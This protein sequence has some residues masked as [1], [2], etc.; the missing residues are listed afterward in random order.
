MALPVVTS[1]CDYSHRK[2]IFTTFPMSLITTLALLAL[3]L[4][5]P[6][7]ALP[8]QCSKLQLPVNTSGCNYAHQKGSKYFFQMS[9]I[10]TGNGDRKLSFLALN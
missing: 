2:D 10:R 7:V 3:F 8:M 1:G 5:T 6:I 4:Q 9:I